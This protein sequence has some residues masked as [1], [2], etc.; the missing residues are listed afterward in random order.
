MASKVD[1][2]VVLLGQENSGKTC[3]VE[4]YRNGKFTGISQNVI[5][6]LLFLLLLLL[7]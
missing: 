1:M 7:L 5:L 6:L 3:L 2:K 4:R